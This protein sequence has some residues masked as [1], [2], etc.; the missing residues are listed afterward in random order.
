MTRRWILAL[1]ATVA[2]T[3][4][5]AGATA[6]PARADY[7]V[8]F[9]QNGT[10]AAPWTNGVFA[11]GGF[12][13][14]LDGCGSGQ[15]ISFLSS[16]M[17]PGSTIGAEVDAPPGTVL[18]H[19]TLGFHSPDVTGGQSPNL[20]FG[21]GGIVL[22]AQPLGDDHSGTSLDSALPATSNFVLRLFCGGAGTCPPPPGNVVVTIGAMDL[23]LHD[24][25]LPAVQATGG[26]LAGDATVR[27]VQPIVYSA[28]DAGSGVARVTASIGSTLLGTATSAC[29]PASLAP[30]P[31]TVS[32][33]LALDTR[34]IPDGTYPLILTAADDSGNP[35]SVQVSTVTVANHSGS[36]PVTVA[37]KA[38]RGRLQVKVVAAWSW[39]AKRT[40]L[41]ALALDKLPRHVAVRLSCRGKG[42]PRARWSARPGRARSLL[43]HLRHASFAAGDRLT[44]AISEPGHRSERIAI[45]IRPGRRPLMRLR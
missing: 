12:A 45:R 32:G 44:L 40:R 9:C 10:A 39:T 20:Q 11:A 33:T 5:A 22:T 25:G 41:K 31:P 4:A 19:A 3:V 21:Y 28:T 30:C 26:T 8:A 7:T 1:V 2:A 24:T 18:T 36:A 35:A 29:Q 14:I 27:G 37:P 13:G 43:S 38:R 16:E 17:T 23:T 42:C 6:A 34:L 15:G